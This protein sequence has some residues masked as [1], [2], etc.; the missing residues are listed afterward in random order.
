MCLGHWRGMACFGYD[1]VT[2]W[3]YYRDVWVFSR[4]HSLLWYCSREKGGYF[5]LFFFHAIHNMSF[6]VSESV[7]WMISTLCSFFI[8]GFLSKKAWIIASP[9]ILA[10]II[11]IPR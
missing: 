6:L 3:G 1:E 4:R 2:L 9:L 10:T 11:P 7:I 8:H 5:S